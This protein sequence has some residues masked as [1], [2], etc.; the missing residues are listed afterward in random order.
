MRV[1]EMYFIEAEA[2]A[3]QD[4]AQG[5]NL[6]ES[7]M[8]SYRYASYSCKSDDVDDVIDEIILQK[9]IELWGEG[10]TYF[11]VKRL[12]MSVN[13]KYT[14]TNFSNMAQL[15]TNGRPAWMNFCIVRSEEANNAGVKGWNNPDP[16]GK[17]N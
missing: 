11:D 4:A 6:L 15:S 12:N 3:H 13:R 7:F 14:D 10:Q 8:R 9:R 5:K 16:S 1:E 2:A 17:Y